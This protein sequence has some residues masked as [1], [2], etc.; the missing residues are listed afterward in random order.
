MALRIHQFANCHR[1]C[2]AVAVGYR[3]WVNRYL[4]IAS[5]T[6]LAG[7]PAV[8]HTAI[9]GSLWDGRSA[10]RVDYLTA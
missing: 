3:T 2:T 10:S 7:W 4:L 6:A 9:S 8:F 1:A 5:A